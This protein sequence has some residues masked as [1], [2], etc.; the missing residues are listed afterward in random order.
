MTRPA[1][2]GLA[3]E[4][5]G[6]LNRDFYRSEPH[7]YLRH[8][9]S[10]LLLVAGRDREL[11][12]LLDQGVSFGD[13]SMKRR[14]DADPRDAVKDDE[15][16]QRFVALE[17]ELLL[18][19][20]CETIL[21][22]FVAHRGP[23]ACPWLELARMRSFEKFKTTVRETFLESDT[24]NRVG[25]IADVFFGGSDRT[26]INPEPS[27]ESWEKA[28][29]NVDRFLVY[30]ANH[31]LSDAHLYNAAKHGLAVQPG[32]QAIRLDLPSAP[33]SA[34]GMA[35]QFL[36]VKDDKW[37]E[38]V[39]W[40]QPD[41]SVVYTL[42]AIDLIEQLWTIARVRYTGSGETAIQVFDGDPHQALADAQRKR[43][44]GPIVVRTMSRT[45]HYCG[46]SPGGT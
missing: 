9:L 21:R 42:T 27:I 31:Y 17:A 3:T 7:L 37:Q 14:D 33:I 34:E 23:P 26:G 46:S 1:D 28:L 32:E 4:N 44:S 41:L 43:A 12:E 39:A 11:R 29:G 8:R 30:Y 24:S 20:A 15:S 18:H 25:D 45:L 35:L 6:W 40:V 2:E 38:T 10:N 36:E 22:L 5:Y 19:H 16:Q 13:L